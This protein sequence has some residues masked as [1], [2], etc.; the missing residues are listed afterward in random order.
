MP[1][2]VWARGSRGRRCTFNIQAP[3]DFWL[4]ADQKEQPRSWRIWDA[5][6]MVQPLQPVKFGNTSVVAAHTN[7]LVSHNKGC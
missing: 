4:L 1:S 7:Y 6:E 2:V 5:A 3:G